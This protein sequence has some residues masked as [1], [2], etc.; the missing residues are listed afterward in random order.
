MHT[1]SDPPL[2]IFFVA[3]VV[4]AGEQSLS[5]PPSSSYMQDDR[6][7]SEERGQKWDVKSPGPRLLGAQAWQNKLYNA[8]QIYYKRNLGT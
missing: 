4:V 1:A 7:R 2:V 8:K 6:I 5:S 3:L